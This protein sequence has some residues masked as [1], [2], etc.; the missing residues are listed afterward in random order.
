MLSLLALVLVGQTDA[1]VLP[2][3]D[4]S[5]GPA[6]EGNLLKKALLKAAPGATRV[7]VL[8][9]DMMV[10]EGDDWNTQ[11][12]TI[13]DANGY[14]EFDL[15][16][17]APIAAAMVQADNN[18]DYLLSGSDDGVNWRLLW[19]ASLDPLPG[20]RTRIGKNLNGHARYLRLTAEGGDK[21]YSMGELRVYPDVSLL[22][23][24]RLPRRPPPERPEP[25][26][27]AGWL[28]T[29]GL[30]GLFVFYFYNRLQEAKTP[31]GP[32]EPPK[33]T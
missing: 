30:I 26:F 16:A 17:D 1:G 8:R 6:I 23:V 9:D 11:W 29:L 24:D 2:V 28:L 12:T 7:E 20:M 4:A 14:I 32:P 25:R 3:V 21:M 5:A 15:G 13:L 18:E 22:D 19:R 10:F 31:A 33:P 27:D